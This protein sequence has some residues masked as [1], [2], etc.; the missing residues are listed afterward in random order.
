MAWAWVLWYTDVHD[1][2]SDGPG[3]SQVD[4]ILIPSDDEF[5]NLDGRSDTSFESLSGL[6]L[7]ARN[8]IKSGSVTG[9]GK[10]VDAA[11]DDNNTLEQDQPNSGI[12]G[13]PS[14]PNAKAGNEDSEGDKA[15]PADAGLP[16]QPPSCQD[17]INFQRDL[18]GQCNTNLEADHRPSCRAAADDES[19]SELE[20]VDAESCLQPQSRCGT[21]SSCGV[22][23]QQKSGSCHLSQHRGHRDD[24]DRKVAESDW[25]KPAADP[26]RRS[27]SPYSAAS[28]PRVETQQCSD[29][30]VQDDRGEQKEGFVAP[31]QAQESRASMPRSPVEGSN[32]PELAHT[33]LSM[34]PSASPDQANLQHNIGRHRHF[35]PSDGGDCGTVA[36]SVAERGQDDDVAQPPRKRREIRTSSPTTCRT[37]PEPQT[38]LH[39]TGQAQRRTTQRPKSRRSQCPSDVP[40]DQGQ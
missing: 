24:S 35:G 31:P 8:K 10:G 12:S 25:P 26:H 14:L 23:P 28:S 15:E 40:E 6:L 5:D 9:T 29:P 18:G 4:A 39:R 21:A 34:Q 33:E 36:D 22:D 20:P 37:T 11:S 7:D 17:Q 16:P 38:R 13:V 2:Q 32:A 27:Q 3:R 1:P 19:T 30:S